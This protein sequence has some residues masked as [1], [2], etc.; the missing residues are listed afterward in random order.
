MPIRRCGC[1]RLLR[2]MC[3]IPL[4]GLVAVYLRNIRP[5]GIGK[6]V[7]ELGGGTPA[8][9]TKSFCGTLTG[10]ETLTVPD[11]VGD[12]IVISNGGTST[13]SISAGE[14]SFTVGTCWNLKLSSGHIFDFSE[15]FGVDVF[16][17]GFGSD[18]TL[19]DPAPWL[20]DDN[21]QD[22]YHANMLDG[23]DLYS[24]GVNMLRARIGKTP[25]DLAMV[26]VD[27]KK[28]GSFH[29]GA[30]SSILIP[31]IYKATLDGDCPVELTYDNMRPNFN[32]T[33]SSFSSLIE[34]KHRYIIF[35][36]DFQSIENQITIQGCLH[37]DNEC[38]WLDEDDEIMCDE[39]GIYLEGC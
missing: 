28:S 31:D 19:N 23:F 36:D 3:K 18:G 22:E 37:E 12:E 5:T 21:F 35:Y 6:I 29:N 16:N 1:A 4:D 9:I 10:V 24:D 30:E 38:L 17:S 39:N 32:G 2:G 13:P 33:A 27:R 8:Q 26:F 15:G 14:I 20:W 11:L 34:D 7:N 25:T